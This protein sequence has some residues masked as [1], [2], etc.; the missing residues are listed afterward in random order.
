MHVFWGNSAGRKIFNRLHASDTK[1]SAA[2]K[3]ATQRARTSTGNR[4]R[5]SFAP[6]VSAGGTRLQVPTYDHPSTSPGPSYVEGRADLKHRKSPVAAFPHAERVYDFGDPAFARN[7]RKAREE[8]ISPPPQR[9]T[10]L[11][12]SRETSPRLRAKLSPPK[13]KPPFRTDVVTP[14]FTQAKRFNPKD[15]GSFLKPSDA[16]TSSSSFVPVANEFWDPHVYAGG[17]STCLLYTSPSPRDR[18]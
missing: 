2:V 5:L 15:V 13:P 1:S 17:A 7:L 12:K 18:G 14:R 9:N 4:S 11:T 8:A 16:A 6:L 3:A 10:L